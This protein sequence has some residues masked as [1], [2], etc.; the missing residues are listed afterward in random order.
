[1]AEHLLDFRFHAEPHAL[2]V[3]TDHPIPGGLRIVRRWH[4]VAFDAGIIKGAVQPAIRLHHFFDHGLCLSRL[5]YVSL[6]KDRV[7]PSVF[8]QAHGF[9]SAFDIHIRHRDF[10]AFPSKNLSGRPADSGTR[11]RD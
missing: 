8:D 2:E 1:M 10:C 3:N 4:E 9:L 7:A 11:T 6:D 5:G